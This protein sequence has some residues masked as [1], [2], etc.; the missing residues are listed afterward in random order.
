[1]RFNRGIKVLPLR[2]DQITKEL[3]VRTTK[4]AVVMA[5]EGCYATKNTMY[6]FSWNTKEGGNYR[7]DVRIWESGQDAGKSQM[8]SAVN[9]VMYFRVK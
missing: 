5:V 3:A 8:G 1:M 7:G 9:M 2:E 6:G 4:W